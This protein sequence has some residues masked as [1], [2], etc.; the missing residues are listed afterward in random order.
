M[1]EA[2]GTNAA[3]N[4]ITIKSEK[5]TV[6]QKHHHDLMIFVT[7]KMLTILKR[8]KCNFLFHEEYKQ[9]LQALQDQESCL[10]KRK[11]IK[12]ACIF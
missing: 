7:C 10:S 11:K 9:M 2:M 12:V 5:S 3:K 4:Q 8:S 1:D 6:V